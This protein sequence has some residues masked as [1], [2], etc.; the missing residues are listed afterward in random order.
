[1]T[2]TGW[3]EEGQSYVTPAVTFSG[4]GAR[5]ARRDSEPEGGRRVR[6][7]EGAAQGPS[8]ALAGAAAGRTCRH[9]RIVATGRAPAAWARPGGAY[10]TEGACLCRNQVTLKTQPDVQLD[11]PLSIGSRAL[12]EPVQLKVQVA[13]E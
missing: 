3:E 13:H 11:L 2:V 4:R 6:P 10:E 8:S 9:C 1:M 12:P 7:G 5:K